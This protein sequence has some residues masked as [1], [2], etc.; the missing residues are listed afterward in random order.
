MSGWPDLDI[1]VVIPHWNGWELLRTCLLSLQNQ[2]NRRF[3][4]IVVDNGSTDGSPQLI[5]EQFPWVDVVILPENR[6]FSAAVNSGIRSGDNP[7]ILLLNND[8]EVQPDCLEELQTQCRRYPDHEFFALKMCAFHQRQVIDG[9]GDGVLRGGV[10][11][12]L[13]TLEPDGPDF[14]MSREVFGACAGAA[15]YRREL[16]DRVGLFDEDFFA[17][18][19]DVDFNL[20]AVRAG[21]RCRYLPEAVVYHIGSASSGSK[22]NPF[23]I[24]LSTRNNVYVIAKHYSPALLVRF[25]PALL[26]YQFFWFLFVVKKRQFPAYLVG[27]AESLREVAK[28]R[29]RRLANRRLARLSERDFAGR[30]VAAERDVIRS[31]ISRRRHQGKGNRIFDF[32][33]RLFC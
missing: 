26:I 29:R 2:T 14:A 32:Y 9:A 10:G 19:E 28:M 7:W 13:G 18:L 3:R 25:A 21:A 20:R 23:V 5:R 33:L 4:T 12:R 11:Y 22:V 24:R 8:V 6:G 31:I 27:L 1:D 30:I 16:F 17:Y 15:L